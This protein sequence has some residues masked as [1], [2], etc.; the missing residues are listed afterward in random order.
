MS[1]K[2]LYGIRG[3]LLLVLFL[4]VDSSGAFAA[5]EYVPGEILV[6]FRDTSPSK[7]VSI[8]TLHAHAGAFKKKSYKILN[9]HHMKLP[10]GISVEEAVRFYQQD[11]NVEYAE[12]NYIVRVAATMPN[13]PRFANLWGLDNG[14]DTDIDAPEAWDMTTGSS[15]VIIAVVD[16]G[17]AYNHTDLSGNVWSNTGETSV[18]CADGIDND[19]N[20]YIDDCHGWDF[21]ND[22]NDPAD[23]N[24]HGTH[25]AGTIAAIGNNGTG[26]TGI[27]WQAKI[28]P[29]RFLGIH[30]SGDTSDAIAAILYASANGAHVINN[31]WGGGGYSQALKDAIDI[32]PAVVICAAGN[33]GSDGIGDN[34]DAIPF[35]P[36]SYSS[37][38]IIS[39]A[40]TGNTDTLASFSNYGAASVDLSAPGVSIDS[41]VPQVSSGAPV[42]VYPTESFNSTSGALPLLG[43]S[44]GGTNST[45]AITVGTGNTGN[46]LEDSPGGANYANNTSSWAGY[47]VAIDSSDKNN[48]YTLSFKW[49]GFLENNRDYLGIIY[50]LDHASWFGVDERTGTQGTFIDYSTDE[51]TII[52]EMF[53]SFYFGFGLSSDSSVTYDGVYLDDVTLTRSQLS[54][55]GDTYSSNYSGTSMASSHVSGVAGLIKAR[56][57]ALSNTQVK[58]RILNNIDIIGSLSGTVVSGGR[59][60]AY[61]AL[62]QVVPRAVSTSQINISWDDL[63]NEDGYKVER[64]TGTGGTFSE[65]ASTAADVTSHSD[66][67]LSSGTTYYYRIR[68][69]GGALNAE[70]VSQ[71]KPATTQSESSGGGGSG[72]GGGGCFIATAAYGS[73]LHPYVKELRR[74]RD[75]H[76]LTNST[77]KAFVRLYYRYTPPLAAGIQGD[78]SLRF[79][80][81]V[82][83]TPLVMT[84]VYPCLSLSVLTTLII[85]LLLIFRRR[86]K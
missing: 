33:G 28:M 76:L 45:W 5:A 58:E 16:T 63:T 25:V 20:G 53:D 49:K 82:M 68:A 59:L 44:T 71:E 36:A 27:M 15:S 10:K 52:A 24:E 84:V 30:G 55:S 18:S 60:N 69:F 57:P 21:L 29:L 61:H 67:G 62:F 13:D 34:N 11:P 73:P 86:R 51:L 41:T 14:S 4:L 35:Y 19:G 77:G 9:I 46:S 1:I 31:S 43:W 56:Y 48:I 23:Y 50:S 39:V 12:P 74:F 70:I 72:G 26:I 65:I 6:K 22:D 3:V 79:L 17:I 7:S 8:N 32:S 40:A 47:M 42:T 85:G 78:D 80:T 64:K 81:R 66:S 54:I 83:L 37:A 2:A 75:R 38:N